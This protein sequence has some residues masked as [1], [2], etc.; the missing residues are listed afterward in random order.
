MLLHK[1]KVRT[2]TVATVVLIASKVNPCFS[3][4]SGKLHS[5]GVAQTQVIDGIALVTA[6][7]RHTAHALPCLQP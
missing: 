7:D 3:G 1:H 6:C 2:I 5:C 4:S